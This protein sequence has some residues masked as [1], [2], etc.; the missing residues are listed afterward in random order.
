MKGLLRIRIKQK[1]LVVLSGDDMICYLL[2]PEVLFHYIGEMWKARSW[3]DTYVTLVWTL[4][5]D[6][7]ATIYM[8]ILLFCFVSVFRTQLNHWWQK[9]VMICPERI[10]SQLCNLQPVTWW[11]WGSCILGE[12]S[13]EWLFRQRHF[14]L[15]YTN[16]HLFLGGWC[17]RNVCSFSPCI[18]MHILHRGFLAGKLRQEL[19]CVLWLI[20]F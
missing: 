19:G 17:W 15:G 12:V 13:K 14:G 5:L 3:K 10:S 18:K 9:R 16:M 8:S 4:F 11:I 2:F 6:H 1:K 7:L 20:L